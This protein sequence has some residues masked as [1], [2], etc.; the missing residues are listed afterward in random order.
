MVS[1][2]ISL[3]AVFLP[4]LMMGGIVGRYFREFAITLSASI[5]IS[6]FISLTATPMMAARLIDDKIQPGDG[7]P[8]AD[9]RRKSLYKRVTGKLSAMVRRPAS[10]FVHET[11]EDSLNWALD[12]SLFMLLTLFAT[13]AL[14]VWLY[15]IVP[16]GF[17]PQEDT[18]QI[19]GGVQV[20]QASSFLLTRAKFQQHR[21]HHPARTRRSRR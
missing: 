10:T 17:F 20:D 16:K 11:Y 3:I 4:I 7:A 8:G 19:Q 18:G 5:L 15:V 9:G 12:H 13:I 6:L 21:R 14:T 1:M 2:S